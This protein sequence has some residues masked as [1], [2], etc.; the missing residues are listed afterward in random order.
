M[1]P[2]TALELGELVATLD[3]LPEGLQIISPDW[4]YVYVNAAAATHGRRP[5]EELVGNT[6]TSCYP[7]I[8][9]TAVFATL[10]TCMNERVSASVDNEF[11]FPDGGRGSFELR[12]HPCDAG[13]A[14]LSIDVT[15]HRDRERRLQSTVRELSTPVVRVYPGILLQPLVGA[16]DDERAAGLADS[17]LAAISAHEARVVMFDVAG[18]PALDT[19]VARHLLATAAAVRLLGA[20][21]I[22]TGL[23]AAAARSMVHLGLDLAPMKTTARLS[24]GLELALAL[25]GKAVRTLREV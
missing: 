2:S 8:E 22:L 14:I 6:M 21:V 15:E 10:R 25:V 23:S 7:G 17:I 16:F 20:E 11:T 18:V 12:I 5:R 13:L 19:S 4:R 1:P 3:T 9:S 24:D